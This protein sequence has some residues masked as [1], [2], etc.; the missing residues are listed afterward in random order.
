MDTSRLRLLFRDGKSEFGI[1]LDYCDAVGQAE[2]ELP[3]G[4]IVALNTHAAVLHYQHQAKSVPEQTLSF[5]ID[6]GASFNGYA[7]DITRTYSMEDNDFAALISRF[8]DLQQEL[9]GEVRF[10]R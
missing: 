7:S 9:V 8:D 2:H 4:N 6:A 3:Y 5:L 10:G 1:H